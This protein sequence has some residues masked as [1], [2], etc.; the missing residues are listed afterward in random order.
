MAQAPRPVVPIDPDGL[1]GQ[2][3]HP[4]QPSDRSY[5]I[6]RLRTLRGRSL[7]AGDILNVEVFGLAI[8]ELDALW[9]I[10]LHKDSAISRQLEAI[11]FLR[12]KLELHSAAEKLATAPLLPGEPPRQAPHL[13]MRD[14]PP[15]DSRSPLEL[16]VSEATAIRALVRHYDWVH[17]GPDRL[18]RCWPPQTTAPAPLVEE[19]VEAP[20]TIADLAATAVKELA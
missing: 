7:D 6:E 17:D 20:G 14:N 11:D 3:V 16:V 13:P 10:I 8:S 2:Q 9:K 5:L 15:P 12:R 1:Y 19:L 18:L 4:L